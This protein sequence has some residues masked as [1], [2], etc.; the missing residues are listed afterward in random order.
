[1]DNLLSQYNSSEIKKIEQ[2]AQEEHKEAEQARSVIQDAF[3]QKKFKEKSQPP[4]HIEK[5]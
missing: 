2:K 5:K 1:V 3:F 4:N